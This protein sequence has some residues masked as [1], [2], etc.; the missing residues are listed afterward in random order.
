MWTCPFCNKSEP[1][2]FQIGHIKNCDKTPKPKPSE[3]LIGKPHEDLGYRFFPS[4][5]EEWDL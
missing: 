3:K 2:T 4:T 5:K 1:L